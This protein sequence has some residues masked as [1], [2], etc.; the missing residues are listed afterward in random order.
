MIKSIELRDVGKF[1]ELDIRPKALTI[2]EG[3]NGAGKSTILKA[4]TDLF[5]G[6]HDPSIIREGAK[7]A[8][9][10]LTLQDDTVIK[11]SVTPKGYTLTV[12]TSEGQELPSPGTYVKNLASG[13]SMDPIA[14]VEAGKLGAEGWKRRQKFLQDA[15]PTNFKAEEITAVGC[16]L[17]APTET[18]DY[19]IAGVDLLLKD[20]YEKRK[21]ANARVESCQRTVTMLTKSLPGEEETDWE[22]EAKKISGEIQEI[23]NAVHVE[24]SALD[25]ELSQGLQDLL[26]NYEKIKA[27]AIAEF[28]TKKDAVRAG[29]A[30]S[31]KDKQAALAVAQERANVSLS[32]RVTRENIANI[33]GE[34]KEEGDKAMALDRAVQGLTELKKR[35]LD[36]VPVDGLEIRDGKIYVGGLDFDTQLNTAAQYTTAFQIAALAPGELG[37]M[38]CDRVESLE[39]D[40]TFEEFKAAAIASGFQIFVARV[41]SGPLKISTEA[42]QLAE[43]AH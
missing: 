29:I 6:G 28:G 36:S 12:T 5:N 25:T 14:F 10:T 8:L 2:L 38:V 33:R 31:L 18:H 17:L 35:K 9:V 32:A 40:T 23:N 26:A 13:F 21:A 24:V 30:G 16:A 4:L 20:R 15:I 42:A 7:K 41:A 19:D 11:K 22:A 3:T 1:E 43:M 27:E 39:S 34:A 37:L